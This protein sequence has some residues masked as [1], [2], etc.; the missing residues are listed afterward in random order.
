MAELTV[1]APFDGAVIDRVATQDHAFVVELVEQPCD[2]EN[3]AGQTVRL[4][5]LCRRDNDLRH[6]D[7]LPHQVPF[8]LLAQPAKGFREACAKDKVFVGRDFPP[9]EKTHCR[10]SLGTMDEMRRAT[11]VFAKVLGIEATD[12]AAS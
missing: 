2:I 6:P 11:E 8:A 10:I 7:Q 5:R 1:S 12:A 3:V 4:P 9:M